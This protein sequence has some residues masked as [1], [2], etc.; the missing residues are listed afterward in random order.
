MPTP[1][2][3]TS[4][5][6][7]SQVRW[8]PAGTTSGAGS[9]SPNGLGHRQRRNI[10]KTILHAAAAIAASFATASAH[11]VAKPGL[12]YDTKDAKVTLVYEHLLPD[13]R[14][15]SIKGVL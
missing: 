10:M 11:D 6:W 14:G 7:S 2:L 8:F 1:P 9:N 3:A 5:Q 15:K 12:V 4:V 13:V